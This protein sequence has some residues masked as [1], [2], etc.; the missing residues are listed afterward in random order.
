MSRKMAQSELAGRTALVTGS[1]RGIGRATAVSLAEAGT[2]VVVNYHSD[3]E[4][5]EETITRIEKT[6]QEAVAVQANVSIEDDLV[7]LV[8]RAESNFGTIDILVNNAG[9]A[10]KVSTNDLT[11]REWDEHMATNLTAAFLL[12]KAVL[13]AMREQG[14][15]RIVNVSSVAAQNGGITGPHYAASKAGLL[16]LTRSYARQLA[17]E[18]ITVNAIAPGLIATE[19]VTESPVTPEAVPVGRFGRPSEVARII[20]SVAC[21]GY[22]TGQVINIDGGIHF[23]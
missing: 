5:A 22:L 11:R 4:A 6:D 9:I 17:D 2:D 3:Q 14:W 13:P 10:R 12:T 20:Q 19:T 23:Q 16:G 15:G 21:N 7:A 18:G 8:E 1:S